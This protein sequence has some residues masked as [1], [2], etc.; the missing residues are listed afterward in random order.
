MRQA[1]EGNG[2]GKGTSF[3]YLMAS[4]VG[5]GPE[6]P[7]MGLPSKA[8]KVHP[9]GKRS[10]GATFE[11]FVYVLRPGGMHHCECSTP[12]QCSFAHPQWPIILTV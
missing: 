10:K 12:K 7:K 9:L 1:V 3:F 4:V 5:N 6:N 2:T 11:G 8:G